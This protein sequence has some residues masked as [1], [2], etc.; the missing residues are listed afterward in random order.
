MLP[1]KRIS[2]E[3]EIQKFVP[4]EISKDPLPLPPGFVWDSLDIT[5]DD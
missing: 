4:E 1:N 5:D 2:T 3:G